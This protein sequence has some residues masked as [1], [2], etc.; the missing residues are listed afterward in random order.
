MAKNDEFGRT[1]LHASLCGAVCVIY[2]GE[3]NK[4]ASCRS[5]DNPVDRF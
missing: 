3:H 1:E 2:A 5:R 4:I